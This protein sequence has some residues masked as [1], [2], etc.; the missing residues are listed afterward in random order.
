[1]KFTLKL[2]AVAA[3]M[4]A[5][6]FGGHTANAQTPEELW[7]ALD[8]LPAAE[9]EKKLIEGAKKEGETPPTRIRCALSSSD[10]SNGWSS[11]PPP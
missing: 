5:A 9:R 8:K 10:S 11:S 2:A 6:Y 7:K 3:A 4:L 1:M